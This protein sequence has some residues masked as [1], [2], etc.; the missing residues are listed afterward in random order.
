MELN[1][2][3]IAREAAHYLPFLLTTTILMEA[4]K[5]G[6]GR[7][8]AHEII[9]EHAVAT[10]RD[11]RSGK[12]ERNDLIARL[13]ADSRLGL[14]REKLEA[15]VASAGGQTGAAGAQVDAFAGRVAEWVVRFPESGAVAPGRML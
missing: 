10:A 2:A 14:S 11:L 12:V 6:V 7:E 3:V 15:L 8:T 13:A 4:V 1:T 5:A 9:K